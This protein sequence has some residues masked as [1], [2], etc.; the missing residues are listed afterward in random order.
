MFTRI[1]TFI[2]VVE[3]GNYTKAAEVVGLSPSAI[4]RQISQL[5]EQVEGKLLKRTARA[6]VLTDIGKEYYKNATKIIRDIENLNSSVKSRK[7]EIKGTLNIS[8]FESF[9]HKYVSAL[10]PKFLK[11]H[12]N[13]SIELDLSNQNVDLFTDSYDIAIRVGVPKDSRLVVR[14]LIRND[15]LLCASPNY[16]A[17]HG[18]VH[19]PNE[20][21]VHNCLSLSRAR[22][23]VKWCF[24]QKDE[25]VNVDVCGNLLSAGGQTL[26]EAAKQDLGYILL[27]EWM[28]HKD[29]KKGRLMR[30]LDGWRADIGRGQ[31]YVY[32]LKDKSMQ[33]T[34]HA[35]I[36]FLRQELPSRFVI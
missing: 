1:S 15:M 20:L 19:H 25:E 18:T 13:L 8:V 36:D 14:P 11:K 16:I 3:C 17:Q 29:L 26:I 30:C 12:P 31:I 24:T 33:K 21:L 7:N 23:K 35:F 6:V 22:K 34:I 32:Y 5:E 10:I 28:V 2:K 27:P 9:G 4:S